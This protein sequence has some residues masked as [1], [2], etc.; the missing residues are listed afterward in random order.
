MTAAWAAWKHFGADYAGQQVHYYPMAYGREEPHTYPSDTVYMVDFSLTAAP[1]VALCERVTKVV[2]LDHHKTA[3]EEVDKVPARPNLEVILDMDRS[4]ASITWDYFHFRERPNI[5]RYAE[6]HDLWR[7]KL[8]YSKEI[9]QWLRMFD[10]TLED[11][12]KAAAILDDAD[13]FAAAAQTGIAL[14]KFQDQQVEQ[15]AKRARWLVVGGVR[16]PVANATCFFSEVGN[17]LLELYPEAPFAG[18]YM[19]RGD[20]IRQWGLRSRPGIDIS[21]IAKGYGGG[22]HAQAAGWQEPIDKVEV[23]HV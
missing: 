10:Y 14:V 6:D 7:F 20:G 18:Y 4:G 17:R 16:V 9:R 19:D 15:M 12:D 23:P 8:P 11:W 21:G 3:V 2:L 22:G 13:G 1:L 5:V